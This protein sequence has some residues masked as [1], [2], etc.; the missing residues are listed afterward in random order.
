[1]IQRVM[2]CLIACLVVSAVAAC[3]QAAVTTSEKESVEEATLTIAVPEGFEWGNAEEF[4]VVQKAV[5]DK[6]P[7]IKLNLLAQNVMN[8]NP[9]G[10]E[11]LIAQNDI[12]DLV[13]TSSSKLAI[14]DKLGLSF[15]LSEYMKKENIDLSKFE[16]NAIDMVRRG[17]ESGKMI[18][19]PYNRHYDAL[20]FNKDIF[21]KFAVA[22]PTKAMTWT[23]ARE[24]AKR[25]TRQQDGVQYRG[26]EPNVFDRL[27][28]QLELSYVDQK[29][30]KAI[31]TGPGWSSLMAFVK[32]VYDIPG[33]S[34][35]VAN[36]NATKQFLKEQRLAML[37]INNFLPD[38][39]QTPNLKWGLVAVPTFPEKPTSS[40][41]YEGHTISIM[42]TS[43]HKDEAFKVIK[44]I[45]SD[46]F[47]DKMMR[48][49]LMTTLK[50]PKYRQN[51]TKD[52]LLPKDIDL[53]PIFETTPAPIVY[54]SP[55]WPEEKQIVNELFQK[56]V[57]PGTMD[58][59]TALRQAQDEIDKALAAAGQ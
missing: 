53:K 48:S 7:N 37:P 13:I 4:A 54:Q 55:I 42:A 26:L 40:W 21:D 30:G 29:T 50:D 56:S 27:A 46:D 51:F 5:T 47:V 22:Y 25:L 23:E 58:V 59:N 15:D 34:G 14:F 24:L 16:D 38:L 12:P 6:Y 8:G 41:A 45:I 44:T 43:P 10:L 36:Q 32:S 39:V 9:T 3:S 35:P 1:M 2:K 18:A 28:S 57:L 52:L 49:G 19:I 11:K 20:Y 17:S 33:N 31:V